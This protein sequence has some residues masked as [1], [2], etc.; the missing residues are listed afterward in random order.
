MPNTVISIENLS[1]SYQLGMINT[2][3][4]TGDLQR[5][6]AKMRGLPDPHLKVGEKDHDSRNNG[7]TLWALNDINLQVQQ[8]EAL[9]II[10]RNG[11]GKSTLL[12]I[13]SRVTAPTSGEVKIKGRIASLLEVGTGFHPELTGRENIYLNG[14]IMGMDRRETQRKFDEIVD[15][16]GVEQFIDTPVKRYSR[17]MYVRLAFAVAAHLEPE[18]LIVD[19]VLAVGDAEFQKKCLGKMDDAAHGGRTVAFVSHN[20]QAIRSLCPRCILLDKGGIVIDA[21]T[22]EALNAYNN[23]LRRTKIDAKTGIGNEKYRRGSGRIRFTSIVLKDKDDNNR[24]TF[25]MGETVRFEMTYKV[26]KDIQGLAVYIGL[27][28][29][30]SGNTVTSV[31]RLI[32]SDRIAAGT[33]GTVIIELPDIYIRPG[34]YPL[35]LHISGAIP[36]ETNFDV[37]DDLTPPL[38]VA[39]GENQQQDDF[40]ITK[41]VGYFSIPARLKSSISQNI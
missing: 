23:M 24:F 8:G 40:E 11:A 18:I 41:P 33:T 36:N 2:G 31:R 37:L 10:G 25:A 1:K 3:T 26:F 16:S 17:G 15:F 32:S 19:E 34:E 30:L 29:S 35:Y 6:W 28:S 12:K 27:R 22:E 21:S 20:L 14:A 38:V 7:E 13:L 4:F 39:V 5:W 9:G